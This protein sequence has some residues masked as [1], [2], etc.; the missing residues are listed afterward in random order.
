MFDVIVTADKFRY[1]EAS[2]SNVLHQLLSAVDYLHSLNIAHRNIRLEN[3]LVS[4]FFVFVYQPC[5]YIG[6]SVI[7]C[8]GI[9]QCGCLSKNCN[10]LPILHLLQPTTFLILD[11]TLSSR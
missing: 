4:P 7:F 3:V 10:F 1:T 5:T 8:C 6:E 11:V 9:L 2:A